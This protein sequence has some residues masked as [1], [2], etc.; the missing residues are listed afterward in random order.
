M[1]D[2]G[3]LIDMSRRSLTYETR[4]YKYVTRGFGIAVPG[5]SKEH[6][7]KIRLAGM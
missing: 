5:L 3:N 6:I 1:N 4:L 2:L 7:D